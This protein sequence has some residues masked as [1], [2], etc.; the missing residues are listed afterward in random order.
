MLFR[1]PGS[2]SERKWKGPYIAGEKLPGD[3]WLLL[4][5]YEIPGTRSGK[6]YDFYSLGPDGIRSA[7]DVGNW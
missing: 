7:D 3:P 1:A 2:E 6:A 5:V 4:Y